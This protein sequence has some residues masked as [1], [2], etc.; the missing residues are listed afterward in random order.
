MASSTIARPAD[1]AVTTTGVSFTLNMSAACAARSSTCR[2]RSRS[3]GTLASI[4]RFSGTSITYSASMDDLRSVASWQASTII[5]SLTD[6]VAHRHQQLVVDH[7]V[8][9]RT[10]AASAT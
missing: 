5:S 9:Q 8:L 4:G 10:P 2:A 1:R 6:G 7:V 3:S